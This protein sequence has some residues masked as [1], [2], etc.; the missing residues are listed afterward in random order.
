MC[1]SSHVH[2]S[3]FAR[4]CTHRDV[5]TLEE[6][7]PQTAA[8]LLLIRPVPEI[9]VIGCGSRARPS[10]VDPELIRALRAQ[11]SAVEIMATAKAAALFNILNQEGRRVA[12]ALIPAGTQ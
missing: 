8:A 3:V 4:I 10:A 9:V 7:T 12:A 11:G 2:I 6:A 1:V 5:H